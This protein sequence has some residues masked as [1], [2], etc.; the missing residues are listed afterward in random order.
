[1]HSL[2]E[3]SLVVD[4]VK[5]EGVGSDGRVLLGGKIVLGDI[6]WLD[7]SRAD[8]TFWADG[9]PPVNHRECVAT[10]KHL[11]WKDV[12]CEEDEKRL[13]SVIVCKTSLQKSTLDPCNIII[14]TSIVIVVVVFFFVSILTNCFKTILNKLPRSASSSSF[15]RLYNHTSESGIVEL[16]SISHK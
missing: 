10:D 13:K 6:E 4:L 8:F 3:T 11:A 15:L 2:A 12:K 1:M 7:G 14:G 5:S 16:S 9:Y